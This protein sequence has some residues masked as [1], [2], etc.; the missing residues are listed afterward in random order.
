MVQSEL[1]AIPEGWTNRK[2]E[3]L[4]THS[5]KGIN[6]QNTPEETFNHY[7]IPAFDQSK[8]PSLEKGKRI[9]SNKYTVE[10]NTF[11]VS[12]LNPSTPRIWTIFNSKNGIC[13]TEFQVFKVKKEQYFS[14]VHCFLNS[15]YFNRKLASKAHGTS[16]SHQ[17]VKPED[18]LKTYLTTPEYSVFSKFDEAVLPVL[19]KISKNSQQIQTLF[20]V[21]TLLLPKLIKGDIQVNK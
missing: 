16:G 20:R 1:G 21:Q 14:F 10:D 6:P 8:M 11:L 4:V 7:S 2:L 15:D 9:L 3:N 19:Q 17:R 12:K 5:K 18:I 13:S